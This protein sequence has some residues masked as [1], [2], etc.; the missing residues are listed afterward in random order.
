MKHVPSAFNA[1]MGSSGGELHVAAAHLARRMEWDHALRAEACTFVVAML[2]QP[3]RSE[4]AATFERAQGKTLD[5]FVEAHTPA[6]SEV[7]DTSD[8]PWWGADR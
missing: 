8:P 7:L 3:S 5:A 6:E 2:L 1:A 4:F